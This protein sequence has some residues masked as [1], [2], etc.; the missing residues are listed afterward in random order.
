M[1]LIAFV[2][3]SVLLYVDVGRAAFV[4][5]LSKYVKSWV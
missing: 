2:D 5:A 1:A 4:A 3:I